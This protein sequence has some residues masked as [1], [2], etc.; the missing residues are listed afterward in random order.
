MITTSRVGGSLLVLLIAVFVPRPAAAQIGNRLAIGGSIT[1]RVADAP[2]TVNN[3][4]PGFEMRIGHEQPGWGWVP[5]LFGW[6]DLGVQQSTTPLSARLGTLRM[7][8]MMV[9]Y[10]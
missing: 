6:F 1:I 5:Q 4:N 10:G 7:R 3:V 2:D 9:G 8:P